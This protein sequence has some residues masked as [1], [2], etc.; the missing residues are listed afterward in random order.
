[1]LFSPGEIGYL[2]D[3][4]QHSVAYR[5]GLPFAWFCSQVREIRALTMES[6]LGDRQFTKHRPRFGELRHMA[7]AIRQSISSISP[8]A[9]TAVEERARE[10]IQKR[11]EM[12]AEG[13][14][15]R[16]LDWAIEELLVARELARI[17][18]GVDLLIAQPRS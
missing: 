11:S 12:S 13:L 9:L 1:M 7:T 17:G 6:V 2:P 10:R 16:R 18:L 8:W 3:S 15:M 4:E 14:T 5:P